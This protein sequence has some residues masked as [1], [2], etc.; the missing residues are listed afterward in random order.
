M[1]H[2]FINYKF[3]GKYMNNLGDHLQVL[4]IDYLYSLM[5]VPKKE[6]LYLDFDELKQYDGPPAII[7][8]SL[9][10]INYSEGGMSGRFS[11]KITPIFFGVTMPKDTLVPEE[12][13][14]LKQHEPIGCRDEKAYHTMVKYGISAYLGGCLTVTLPK[15]KADPGKNGKIFIVDPPEKLAPF[16]PDEI[17]RNAIWDTHI[18]Y[19]HSEDPVEV[20]KERYRRY[21][22]EA[23]LMITSLLH[24]SVPSMAFGIPVVLARD[25]LSYRF[26]WVESFLPIYTTEE[27]GDIDW[28]P[29]PVDFEMQKNVVKNLF[30]KRMMGKD[31]SEEIKTIH[32]FYINRKKKDYLVD[33]FITL[34]EFIDATWNDHTKPYEYAVWG[35][36][37][38]AEMTVDYISRNYPNAKLTHVYDI[39]PGIAL[40]GCLSIHPDNIVKYPD[41]TVFVT[42]VTIAA[43]AEKFFKTI[44]KSE[45][46]YKT[47]DII[48]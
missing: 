23:T 25:F 3:R 28:S 42:T 30:F 8:V 14:Y 36:T 13:E 26:A 24:G 48:R 43:S 5:G 32:S 27:Y 39:R 45:Q 20:A 19:S 15:R 12:V 41:E 21:N 35:L 38:M 18:F 4:T 34:Q 1:E 16:I 44:K 9:P 6:I 31:A 29:S 22:D 40:G 46:K 17:K 7:P 2:I 47:L 10:L 11:R 33:V 37:Q